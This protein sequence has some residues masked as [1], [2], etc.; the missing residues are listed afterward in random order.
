MTK[1][2][3]IKEAMKRFNQSQAVTLIGQV[4]AVDLN[5][6]TIDVDLGNGLVIDDVRL[7]G[8][9]DDAAGAY[10]IPTVGSSA[11]IIRILT[12]D[13]FHMLACSQIEKQVISNGQ[14]SIEIGSDEITFNQGAKSSFLININQLITKLGNIEGDLNNLKTAFN[15]WVTVPSDGGAALKAITATWSAASLTPTTVADIKDEKIKH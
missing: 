15:T 7:K 10:Q 5:N 14:V 6:A 1:G 11:L 3:Q 13:E 2:E 9:I 4:K 8:F 12:T